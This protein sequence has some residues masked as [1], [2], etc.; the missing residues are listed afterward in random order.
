M[1]E[2]KKILL[3]Y[4]ANSGIST[5]N[6]FFD[7]IDYLAVNGYEVTV[8]PIE[9]K[10]GL[11][12]EGILH[13]TKNRFDI[14]MVYGGDGTLNHAV[15]GLINENLKMPV[16]YVPSGSTNDFSKSLY[17]DVSHESLDIARWIVEG[18]TFTYDAGKFNDNYFNYVAGFGAFPMV[19]YTTPQH[20]KNSIGYAA[21]ILNFLGSIPGGLSYTT[22]AVIE[23]DG[24]REEGD[25]MFGLI[26]NSVSVG[27][28]QP[29]L[30]KRSSLNDGYFEATMVKSNL[31]PIEI[32]NVLNAL[33]SEDPHSDYVTTF[34]MK[35]AS[36]HFDKPVP[37][38]LDGEDGGEETDVEMDVEPKAVTVFSP[39]ESE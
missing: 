23:H 33:K 21:Y 31:N 9:P 30:I 32:A 20:M 27:G 3:L 6:N 15:N 1:N 26:T 22:H 35:H 18:N 5:K 24:I 11:T 34:Q 13:D 4:N 7:V 36:F 28:V 29:G 38:T 17:G 14:V 25:Y 10:K 8:Y 12:S 37:W 39:K 19:S 16:A 2:K